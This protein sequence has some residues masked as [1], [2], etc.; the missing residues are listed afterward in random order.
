M[1]IFTAVIA[2]LIAGAATMGLVASRN[3]VLAAVLLI[4]IFLIY[5]GGLVFCVYF[6]LRYA[7]FIPVVM[8]E[9]LGVTETIRRTVFLTERR[10]GHIFLTMLVAGIIAY[11]GVI[12]FQMPFLV[13]TIFAIVRG[14]WPPWLAF[15]SSVSGAVGSAITGPISMIAIVLLYYDARIRKEAFDLQF[16]MASLDAP[17]PPSGAVSPA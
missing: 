4:L 8:L 1:G 9:N 10:R 2:V 13:S 14:H 5:L 15:A 11:A 3:P 12:V 17:A 6:A 16:M 7:L